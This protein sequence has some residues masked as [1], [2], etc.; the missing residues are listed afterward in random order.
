M[1]VYLS[2]KSPHFVLI[3][4]FKIFPSRHSAA[5]LKKYKL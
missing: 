3:E 5:I 2:V 1:L 4:V